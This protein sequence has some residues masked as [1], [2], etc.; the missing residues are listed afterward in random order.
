MQG[1]AHS[2]SEENC[3]LPVGWQA[4]LVFAYPIILNCKHVCL[5]TFPARASLAASQPGNAI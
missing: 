2:W 5:F 1:P 4:L 3:R